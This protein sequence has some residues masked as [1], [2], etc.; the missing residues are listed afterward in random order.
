MFP[1]EIAKNVK[2]SADCSIN[3]TRNMKS[4]LC[5]IEQFIERFISIIFERDENLYDI[6]EFTKKQLVKKG[7]VLVFSY[8]KNC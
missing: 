1:E 7:G 3:Q 8:T 2:F 4:I 6:N 5:L